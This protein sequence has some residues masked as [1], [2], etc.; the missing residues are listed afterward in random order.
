MA[1]ENAEL[2]RENAWPA[3]KFILAVMI[4]LYLMIMGVMGYEYHTGAVGRLAPRFLV[5]AAM[6]AACF[7]LLFFV[8][9]M[10]M[11]A[12][13]KWSVSEQGLRFLN[14]SGDEDWQIPWDA[15]S[16]MKYTSLS[17]VVW[18]TEAPVNSAGPSRPHRE[19]LF[20][21]N[22]QARGLIA[23][24]HSRTRTPASSERRDNS[25]LQRTGRAE[26][27]L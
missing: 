9:A 14:A 13:G 18:W 24:W 12:D 3:R 6:M 19:T 1:D 2:V 15:I 23:T 10:A 25:A 16:R 17:L 7:A 27:S 20:V 11:R 4:L 26:R 21:D 8:I 22:E 5:G